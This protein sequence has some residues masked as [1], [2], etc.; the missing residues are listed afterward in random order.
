MR[1][2]LD[3]FGGKKKAMSVQ[4]PNGGQGLLYVV[5]VSLFQ[6]GRK[7]LQKTEKR[8]KGVIRSRAPLTHEEG[9]K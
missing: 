7:K 4:K 8:M 3:M 6:R 1:I 2:V 9:L 5:L